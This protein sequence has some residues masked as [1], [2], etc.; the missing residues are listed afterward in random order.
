MA[1]E[2]KDIYDNSDSEDYKDRSMK[3]MNRT[4]VN[5]SK[6]GTLSHSSSK[7][8]VHHNRSQSF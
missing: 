2:I 3:M 5:K 6:K 1:N 8:K 4:K 7:K